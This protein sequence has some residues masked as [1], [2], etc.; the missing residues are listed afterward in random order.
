MP[1]RLKEAA[2]HAAEQVAGS[3]WLAAAS[4]IGV[5][6]LLAGMTYGVGQTVALDQRAAVT[7]RLQSSLIERVARLENQREAD[8]A[9]L[10]GQEMQ[11]REALASLRTD[12]AAIRTDQQ[13]Q[14]RVL[15]RLENYVDR[16]AARP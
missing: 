6:L 15:T 16:A 7:E 13:S 11:L 10:A 14:L 4:R 1:D 12:L 5:P 2:E 8:Q 9:R 3:I